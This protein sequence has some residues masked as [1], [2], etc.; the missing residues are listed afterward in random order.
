MEIKSRVFREVVELARRVAPYDSTVLITGET[1]TGKEV[2]ARYI[3]ELSPRAEQRLLPVNCGALPETLLESELFGHK[4]GAFT[5]AREDRAGLFEQAEGGIVFLD[6]AADVSPAVQI[7]LLRVLQEGEICRVGESIPRKVNV[8]ILAATNRVIA[9]ELE[10]G[11]FRQDLYYRLGVI[12]IEV[13]PLRERRDDILPLARHFVQYFASKLNM[14]HL[15]LMPA[16]LD[17]LQQYSWPGNVRELEN[18][19]ERA[20]V[21]SE[22]GTIRPCHLPRCVRENTYRPDQETLSPNQSLAEVEQNH[23]ERVLSYT[24]GNKRQAARILGISP[25]TL[26][27]RLKSK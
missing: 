8:R 18:A 12:E 20:A 6:E 14:Q 23:I 1:G 22:D 5:G 15:R 7:R 2:L 9:H 4:A 24:E 16:C 10:A 25:A 26:W 13:P 27:R 17:V 11:H 21:L 19:I 3:H